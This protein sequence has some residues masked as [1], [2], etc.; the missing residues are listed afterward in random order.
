MVGVSLLD[1]HSHPVVLWDDNAPLHLGVL[2]LVVTDGATLSNIEDVTEL[3]VTSPALYLLLQLAPILLVKIR[4]LWTHIAVVEGLHVC[5]PT[6]NTV[7]GCHEVTTVIATILKHTLGGVLLRNHRIPL[8]GIS[9][10]DSC[11]RRNIIKGEADKAGMSL[12][13]IILQRI[14]HNVIR[15]VG[16]I[17]VVR[18]TS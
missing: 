9:T 12:I 4:E 8:P 7:M 18:S 13:Y 10:L 2:Y 11:L 5:L 6:I 1:D 16:D 15:L 3:L 17:I 14:V